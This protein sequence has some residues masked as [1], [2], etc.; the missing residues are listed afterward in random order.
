MFI[1]QSLKNLHDRSACPRGFEA[2]QSGQVRTMG[3]WRTKR[4]SVLAASV[5]W[6]WIPAGAQTQVDLGTQGKN[7]NFTNA[8]STR[9]VKTGVSLPAA[10]SVGELFFLTSAVAGS[11][12]Y[13][14]V[15]TNTWALEAGGGSGGSGAVTVQL[16]GTLVGTRTVE[17]LVNGAGVI[18][19]AV[20]TGARINVQDTADTAVMLTRATAQTGVLF[21]CPSS[22]GS[23]GAYT[24]SMS[25]TLA[26]YSAGMALA[27][28]PDVNGAGGPTT[29]SVD[30]LGARP[31]KL[32][33]GTTDPTPVD[34]LAGRLLP[35]WYDGSVFRQIA[36]APVAGAPGIS[37]PTCSAS[38]R[39][40]LWFA[41]GAAGIKDGLTV[42]A[43]DA[44]DAYAW[45]TL[46]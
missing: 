5:V 19:T 39:G 17:N 35:L 6:I 3:Q 46:Y 45:R 1:H 15:T 8:P 7:V 30:T 28:K 32:A 41:T 10:C 16:D 20:D 29:L 12:L 18:T 2:L 37:Q 26:A 27:W 43:K 9:P 11:N 42:C 34:I 44:A 4:L 24:C 40:R 38:L 25:P 36:S 31:V 22:S 23:S 13:A 33:D 21:L 14:C